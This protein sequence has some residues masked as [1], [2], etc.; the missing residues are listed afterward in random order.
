MCVGQLSIDEMNGVFTAL[1][2]SAIELIVPGS[3]HMRWFGCGWDFAVRH[4]V[5][6]GIGAASTG[7]SR[8]MTMVNAASHVPFWETIGFRVSR[9]DGRTDILSRE[10]LS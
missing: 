10:W 5:A 2:G 4:S 8:Q 1:G 3:L 6:L 9:R 7:R